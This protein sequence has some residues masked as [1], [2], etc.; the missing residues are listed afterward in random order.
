MP[1][2]QRSVKIQPAAVVGAGQTAVVERSAEENVRAYLNFLS[3]P[4]ASVDM[5]NVSRL[6][7]LVAGSGDPVER[8]RHTAALEQARLPDGSA[9][10]AAF[11][12][13]AK[14]W[15]EAES[16][17][18]TA[19]QQM[20]V[21]DDVLRRAGLLRPSRGSVRR[22]GGERAVKR[23]TVA[24][25]RAWA[26]DQPAVFTIKDVTRALGGSLVTANKALQE[27][28]EEG[29]LTNLGPAEDH[30]GPGRAPARF[31]VAK[32]RRSRG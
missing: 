12:R 27:L 18:V 32:R 8:L 2:K 16:I 23:V 13:D 15:A 5:A 9:L 21:P 19:F 4:S 10:L 26:I 30:R 25:V 1:P 6:E 14:A 22:R 28:V 20:G 24:D 7:Q 3:D 29:A 11:V 17:P 31:A